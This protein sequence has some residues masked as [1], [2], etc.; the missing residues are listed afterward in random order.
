MREG[1]EEVGKNNNLCPIYHVIS[2]FVLFLIFET[3][4]FEVKKLRTRE[5]I[6]LGPSD[7]QQGY[8]NYLVGKEEYLQQ[9]VL[10]QLDILMQRHE[11]GC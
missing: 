3:P 6:H 4:I 2:L 11:V 10:E 5:V 7:F 1:G 8:Q 9:M